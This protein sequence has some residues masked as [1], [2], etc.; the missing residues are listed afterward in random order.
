M[1][2]PILRIRVTPHFT[3]AFQKLPRSVQ[4]AAVKRDQWFRVDAFDARLKTHSLTGKLKR[5]WAYSVTYHHR[6]LFEFLTD[7]EVLYQDI[8]THEVY[9]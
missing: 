9:R 7:T 2:R 4:E 6:L 3:R 8:G 1:P 5:L